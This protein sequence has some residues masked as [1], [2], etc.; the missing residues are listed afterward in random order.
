MK[1]LIIDKD[2]PFRENLVV[3]LGRSGV[4]AF[5]ADDYD[6]GRHMVAQ[7]K[8]DVILLGVEGRDRSLMT[9]IRLVRQEYPSSVI[10]LINH[11]GDVHV[12]MEAMKLGA[13]DEVN[14]PVDMVELLHKLKSAGDS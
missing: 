11:S 4:S 3:Q 12:S 9:F 14:A 6:E 8:M 10:I 7:E 1:V 2:E 5:S 13:F